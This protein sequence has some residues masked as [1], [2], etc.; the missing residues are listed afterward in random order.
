MEDSKERYPKI[1]LDSF[2]KKNT[3]DL[4][5]FCNCIYEHSFA[6]FEISSDLV[7]KLK[8]VNDEN[9]KFFTSLNFETKMQT[10]GIIPS[11]I[12]SFQFISF[13]INV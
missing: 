8:C 6:V 4:L 12:F 13:I 11:E 5:A 10:Q 2:L 9:I 7:E 3:S 1:C